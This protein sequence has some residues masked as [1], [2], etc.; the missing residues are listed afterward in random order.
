MKQYLSD[1]D[2][3]NFF[4]I[5]NNFDIRHNRKGIKPLK[6]VEQFEWLFYSLL[7]SLNLYYKLKKKLV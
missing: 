6:Y 2:V 4:D 1:K 5:I 3:N 7:N